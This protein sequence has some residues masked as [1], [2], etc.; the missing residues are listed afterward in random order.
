M[1]KF[2]F[3]MNEFVTIDNL[4]MLERKKEEVDPYKLI[5]ESL[6]LYLS[7]KAVGIRKT[8]VRYETDKEISGVR[9]E[10][11]P[12]RVRAVAAFVMI[13]VGRW[14]DTN[15]GRIEAH[16]GLPMSINNIL[17]DVKIFQNKHAGL[18]CISVQDFIDAYLAS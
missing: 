12:V 13:L 14:S 1:S 10:E 7:L 17:Y 18:E 16:F 4:M 15:T 6:N 2:E 11:L 5:E 8:L 3:N 9:A